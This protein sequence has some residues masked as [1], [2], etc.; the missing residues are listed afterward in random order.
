MPILCSTCHENGF[1]IDVE[2]NEQVVHIFGH[3]GMVTNATVSKNK[4][5][6]AS[7]SYDKTVRLLRTKT[8]KPHCEPL[9]GHTFCVD[10]VSI[11]V[12]LKNVAFGSRDNSFGKLKVQQGYFV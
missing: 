8:L 4:L 3:S 10:C 7:C 5:F 6:I 2:Q 9:D 1:I 12:D 11:D